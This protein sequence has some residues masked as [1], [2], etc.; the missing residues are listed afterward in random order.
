MEE[1]LGEPTQA[2]V[3][4]LLNDPKKLERIGIDSSMWCDLVWSYERYFGR[5][6]AAGRP[7]NM[8]Q[9]AEQ[10]SNDRFSTI[11]KLK[12]RSSI[13]CNWPTTGN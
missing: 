9:D 3:E 7:D 12:P 1:H 13:P 10:Q 11:S 4:L 8:Q 6:R 5:S 2:D